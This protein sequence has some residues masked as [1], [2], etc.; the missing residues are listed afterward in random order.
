MEGT[1]EGCGFF[2]SP[3]LSYLRTM[4]QQ[5]CRGLQA[6]GHPEQQGNRATRQQGQQ[7]NKG[8]KATRATMATGQPWQQGNHGKQG[9]R[10]TRAT[11]ATRARCL[12]VLSQ[13]FKL[14]IITTP[15][16]VLLTKILPRT[17]MLHVCD[18]SVRMAI[19]GFV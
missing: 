5:F 17:Q 19:A 18:R 3:K 13:L 16:I 4:S 1:A 2:C 7:G 14:Q 12:L 11:R 6:A 15:I 9:N 8:N 10:V